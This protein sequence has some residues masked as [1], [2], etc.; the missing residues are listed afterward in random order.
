MTVADARRQLSA[1]LRG[2]RAD[3]LAANVVVVG[4]HRKAEAVIVPV[5][6]FDDPRRTAGSV[7]SLLHRR[8][9]LIASLA[10]A[11]KVLTV[12]LFGSVARGD[13]TAESDIDLLVEPA[14]DATLFDL[15]Q[16]ELDLEALLERPVDVVSRGSLDPE[17]DQA[18][19]AEAV[20]L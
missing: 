2:F 12:R 7:W 10:R 17:R 1:V 16:F 19:L 5:A 11:N 8:R 14:P 9:S 6:Q 20:E 3:G 18:L 4:A 15:A 13:D